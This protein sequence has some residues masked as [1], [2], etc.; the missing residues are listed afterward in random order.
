[1]SVG[2]G[3][4]PIEEADSVPERIEL[5]DRGRQLRLC[6]PGVPQKALSAATLRNACRCAACTHA[7]R[8][9][10]GLQ[11]DTNIALRQ[12]A[13]F[14]VAGLQLVFSDGHGR[15]IFPWA[16]LRQLATGAG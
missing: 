2:T 5:G 11:I 1:L 10:A 8:S 14:G 6:W 16:Y 3:A 7:R 9:G 15:G 13:A 12:V 4:T